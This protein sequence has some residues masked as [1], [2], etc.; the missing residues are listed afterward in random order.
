MFFLLLFAITGFKVQNCALHCLTM[1][2]LTSGEEGRFREGLGAPSFLNF[3]LFYF[4]SN[5]LIPFIYSDIWY[6]HNN[7]KN[8][9][10][11]HCDWFKILLFSRTHSLLP[12]NTSLDGSISNRIQTFSKDQL[13]TTLISIFPFFSM[14]WLFFLF[15]EIFLFLWL[16]GNKTLF[17]WIL[18]V[19]ILVIN[20]SDSHYA[21]V[22]FCYHSY[23][24]SLNWTP[25]SPIIITY[26][27]QHLTWGF[28]ICLRTKA[29]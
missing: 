15:S 26:N 7:L 2:C 9:N 23:H 8:Y 18:S 5:F 10:F 4:I 27:C 19:I 12:D 1:H 13:I 20:K 16:I 3:S 24:Y 22:R 21:V 17:C 28:L 14:T 6:L 11:L 25:L 29:I